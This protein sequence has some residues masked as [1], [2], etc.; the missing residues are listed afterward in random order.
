MNHSFKVACVQ[1]NS[2]I[3]P[4]H[5]L[6]VC[7]ELVKAAH[8][9]GAELICLPEFFMYLDNNNQKMLEYSYSKDNHPALVKFCSLAKEIKAWILLGSISIR[10]SDTKLYNRSYLINSSGEVVSH[11][12]KIHLFDVT[13]DEN[14][15]YAE[16]EYVAAGNQPILANMPWGKLGMSICY[17]LRFAYLYRYLAQQGALFL[18]VPAAFSKKTG[19]AHWHILNRAR[20][21]ETGSYVFSPCQCGTHPGNRLTYGHSLIIDPWGKVL[22]EGG[23]EPCFIIAEVNTQQVAIARQRIPSLIHDQAIKTR[24][25]FHAE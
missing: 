22:A 10:V 11:Y 25:A 3:N 17:D 8:S 2:G 9:K 21:I 13:L 1:N 24:S 20:A 16:S 18:C 4:L 5:N 19:E 7:A 12:D 14:E 6:E 15:H 23:E